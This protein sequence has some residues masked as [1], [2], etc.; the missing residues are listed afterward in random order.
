VTL[1]ECL[2]S[3]SSRLIPAFMRWLATV[4]VAAVAAGTEAGAVEVAPVV[5]VRIP[6][7]Y[8]EHR[9]NKLIGFSGGNAAPLRNSRW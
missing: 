8:N 2:P 4:V 5:E 3:R 1:W 6:T 9:T 7:T